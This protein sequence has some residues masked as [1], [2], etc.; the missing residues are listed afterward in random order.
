MCIKGIQV[1]ALSGE[2]LF[3]DMIGLWRQVCVPR[4]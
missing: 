1:G 4:G 2:N 3:D